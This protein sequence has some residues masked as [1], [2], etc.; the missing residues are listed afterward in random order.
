M[1]HTTAASSPEQ[2]QAHMGSA[3]ADHPT[4]ALDEDEGT[5]EVEFEEPSYLPPMP[6]WLFYGSLALMLPF[7]A[8]N[9]IYLMFGDPAVGFWEAQLIIIREI[10]AAIG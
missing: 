3:V 4:C 9:I 10:W 8:L 7:I 2:S 6:D 1:A 5:M